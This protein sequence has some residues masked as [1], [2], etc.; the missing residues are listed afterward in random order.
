MRWDGV[1]DGGRG[2]GRTKHW[3]TESL[4][5][6]GEGDRQHPQAPGKEAGELA[7]LKGEGGPLSGAG[8]AL[9]KGRQRGLA[10]VCDIQLS[11]PALV[12][13]EGETWEVLGGYRVGGIRLGRWQES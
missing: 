11:L 2:C 5:F 7:V 6:Q 13:L 1:G 3:E 8:S 9:R 10:I 12:R 4:A